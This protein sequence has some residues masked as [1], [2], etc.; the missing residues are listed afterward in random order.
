MTS[1][2]ITKALIVM[3]IY[4]FGLSQA[5]AADFTINMNV[6]LK[7]LR[8]GVS[9][10]RF[11]CQVLASQNTQGVQVGQ[12]S[13]VLLVPATRNLN[14]NL[15]FQFDALP[16]Q[17]PKNGKSY[18]CYMTLVNQQGQV[19]DP[20][21]HKGAPTWCGYENDTPFTNQLMGQL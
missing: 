17:D 3:I 5:F 15:K 16:G 14:Q 10:V 11:N 18:W 6:D 8:E 4:G 21:Q 13:K 12:Q 20:A 19:C 9:K 2:M 1:K 7:N